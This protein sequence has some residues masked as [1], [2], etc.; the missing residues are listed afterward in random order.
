MSENVFSD[1]VYRFTDPIRFFKAND[2]YYFEVDNIPLKQL[3][4]NCLWLKDQILKSS[5]QLLG[6]KRSDIDELRPYASGEDRVIRVKSGRYTS[7]VND[8]SSRIP[9]AFL[10]KI[11]GSAVGDVDTYLAAMPNAGNFP[12][13]ITP[14]WNTLLS[15]VLEKFKSSLAADAL[16]MNGLSDRAFTWPISTVDSPINGGGV[17]TFPYASDGAPVYTGPGEIAPGSSTGLGSSTGEGYSP[18]VIAQALTWAKSLG[19]AAESILLPTWETT[20][21]TNGFAKLPRTESYFIKAWRGVARLAIVDVDSE[22]TVEVPAFDPED[23]NYTDENGV[24]RKVTGVQS[25]VDLIFIYSKPID[26]SGVNILTR[27]GVTK[28]TRPQLGIVKGAGIKSNFKPSAAYTT[29]YIVSTGNT[30]SIQASPGDANNSNMG[31]TST[32][33]NDIAYDIRGSF[34]APDDILNLAPLISEKLESEAFELI[35]QTI[36]PVA[37]VFVRGNA[38]VTL[39]S[40]QVIAST[41]VV[42]IRPF[43][44]TAELTYNE[45]AGIAAAFP[46]LSLANPAV[47]KAELQV[48]EKRLFEYANQKSNE[49]ISQVGAQKS[50]SVLATGYVFGGWNFGPEGALANFY[51]NQF[52]DVD[53]VTDSVAN[54]RAYVTS[55]Y[56]FGSPNANIQVPTYPDWDLAQWAVVQN[57]TAQGLYPNDYINTFYAL[58]PKTSSNAAIVAGSYA[59]KT[60]TNGLNDAG[61]TPSR[62]SLFKNI[63]YNPDASK[64]PL[65]HFHFVSKRIRFDRAS[66]PWLADYKVDVSLINCLA[67]VDQGGN[68][69][70]G[71]AGHW[72]E[73]GFDEFT[74][75][76]AFRA[77][78]SG[79]A[80]TATYAPPMNGSPSVSLRDADDLTGFLVPVR[81]IIAS[82]TNPLSTDAN[83]GYIGF[84]RMAKCTYPTV[85]WTFTGIPFADSAYLYGNLNQSSPAPIISL[86]S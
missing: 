41:D 39:N 67:Q 40:S 21:P 8:V 60:N 34:I 32:S 35:G 75:Y 11:M 25:R 65:V 80:G 9:L 55:K 26:T 58:G 52:G 37:Y 81:D 48:T 49:A 30:P 77:I 56:G 44:R 71:Y 79:G 72:I 2:P 10:Q 59:E 66:T 53:G 38:D 50:A 5:Q 84:P 47:G 31:F 28:I 64:N 45:R 18:S 4:E 70:G 78:G 76:V 12:Q 46:Q 82:N 69:P 43:F 20:N 73:K 7:R 17:N 24:S 22:I 3:H 36:F 13:G 33:G 29:D 14:S 62:L 27:T 63:A 19:S 15:N 83:Q 6:V 1:S 57:V 23:F 85:M 51:L 74:I 42:D 54:A 61:V 16:G 68:S 86:K